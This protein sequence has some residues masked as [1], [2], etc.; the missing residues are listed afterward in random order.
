MTARVT[1][2]LVLTA[3][4]VGAG[5]ALAAGPA[6]A[7]PLGNFTVNTYSG[8]VVRSDGID[9]RFVLDM[10]EIP[11]FQRKGEMDADGDGTIS[12]AERAAFRR[13]A[14]ENVG[15]H[16]SLR[17]DGVGLEPRVRSSALSFPPGQAGLT[18]LRLT[19]GLVATA[20]LSARR[21]V[22]YAS[23]N[24]LDRTGWREITVAGDRVTV[25]GAGV[26]HASVSRE[27]TAYPRSLLQQPLDERA[28]R[29]TATPGGAPLAGLD[30]VAGSPSA[31]LPRGVDRATRAF[32]SF[33][34]RQQV[35]PWFAL[36]AVA[37]S[38]LL[39][40]IH[41]FAPGHGKTVMA[42]YLVGQQGSLRQAALV[43]VTVTLTHTAG[44]LVLGMAISA[45]A[46][47][48]PERLYPWL[49][50]A[51]GLMLAA[52]GC[53]LLLRPWR[54]ARHRG[55]ASAPVDA[56]HHIASDDDDHD[57]DHDDVGSDVHRHGGRAHRHGPVGRGQALTWG[58]ML[59]IGFVGG[60]LPSP[61]AVVV[62]LGAIALHRAW[63]GVVLV[64]AYGVGMALTLTGTGVVL[65]RARGALN[66]RLLAS[67]RG[68]GLRSLDRLVPAVAGAVIVVVGLALAG[69]G[70]ARI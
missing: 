41:A 14:C 57:H 17:V 55:S 58:N 22:G 26:R 31:P 52:V 12:A 61:S 4:T 60:F 65:L 49:G 8:L 10:A 59:A 37:L 11:T 67:S 36:L 68:R 54:M 25:A 23:D 3:A 30:L 62:I 19:C 64:L 28:V 42:A 2:R 53:G 35:S 38:A 32:T 34:A 15:R 33:V 66:R 44:V 6:D 69:Q 5:L 16:I 7:H 39:G 27:L 13:A 70:L 21:Q 46:V 1:R 9:V 40:A 18:T 50:L 56:R 48:A 51:S 29:F 47:I 20:D 43:A 45:S 63:F 24:D